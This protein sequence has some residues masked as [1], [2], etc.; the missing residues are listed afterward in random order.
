M[1]EFED[2][3]EQLPKKELLIEHQHLL[4]RKQTFQSKISLTLNEVKFK[5][6]DIF[7]DKLLFYAITSL[8][9]ISTP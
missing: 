7:E 8:K 9:D 2:S 6:K 4:E 1:E 5:T 3:Q